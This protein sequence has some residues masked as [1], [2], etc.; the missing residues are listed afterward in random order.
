MSLNAYARARDVAELPRASEAR[1]MSQITGELIRARDTGMGGGG[2]IAI[3]HR[4]R[5]LWSIFASACATSGNGLPDALRAQIVSLG[6]WVDRH[7]GLV[8]RAGGS[9]DDLI[10]VNR[11]IIE[12]LSA[13]S[14]AVP[15]AA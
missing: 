15:V 5:E 11:A 8:M 13:S 14:N 12:G 3:L 7:T 4:N 10:S 1:L 6:L 2:L 9:I